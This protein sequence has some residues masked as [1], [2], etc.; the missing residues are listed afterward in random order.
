VSLGSAAFVG[1]VTGPRV[2][3]ETV[4][5]NLRHRPKLLTCSID[6]QAR[7]PFR[8][9]RVEMLS[10]LRALRCLDASGRGG[11]HIAGSQTTKECKWVNKRPRVGM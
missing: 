11:S 5:M 3:L 6:F 8:M 1:E 10:S 2:K 4:S 9:N 7:Q